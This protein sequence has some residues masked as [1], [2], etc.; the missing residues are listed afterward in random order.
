[1]EDECWMRPCPCPRFQN[2]E[3]FKNFVGTWVKR[4]NME[5]WNELIESVFR[6]KSSYPAQLTESII[7]ISVINPFQARFLFQNLKSDPALTLHQKHSLAI[8]SIYFQNFP[9]KIYDP[10]LWGKSGRSWL[11]N[12]KVDGHTLS[13]SYFGHNLSSRNR[14]EWLWLSESDIKNQITENSTQ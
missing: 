6:A 3:N 11:Q 1:M 4:K 12:Q 7:T 8:I 9:S 14:C 10:F 13:Y 5:S 2:F